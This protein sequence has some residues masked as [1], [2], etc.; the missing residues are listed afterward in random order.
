[1]KILTANIVLTCLLCICRPNYSTVVCAYLALSTNSLLA[2]VRVRTGFDPGGPR[3]PMIA[4]RS[5]NSAVWKVSIETRE[6]VC[7]C[8]LVVREK[9]RSAGPKTRLV[10]FL[11]QCN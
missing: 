2:T 7:W 1:M 8:I 9:V 5:E 10:Q 6:I 11:W 4:W 3:L